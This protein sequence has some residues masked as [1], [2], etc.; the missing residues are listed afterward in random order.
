LVGRQAIGGPVLTVVYR[1]DRKSFVHLIPSGDG[2]KRAN[3]PERDRRR[4]EIGAG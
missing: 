1:R 3:E 2:G 4:G